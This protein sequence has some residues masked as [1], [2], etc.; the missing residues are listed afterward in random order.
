MK[1]VSQY[2]SGVSILVFYQL[3]ERR[4]LY[5]YLFLSFIAQLT[6]ICCNKTWISSKTVAILIRK[7]FCLLKNTFLIIN[8]II[9]KRLY[10]LLFQKIFYAR[11]LYL[12]AIIR[13]MIIKFCCRMLYILITYSARRK[14]KH[15]IVRA[16]WISTRIKV[17]LKQQ[18][19]PMS[20]KFV[21]NS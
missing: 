10:F 1:S 8:N 16:K 19:F 7:I 6:V 3:D 17:T 21:A 20:I 13:T 11:V 12:V 14:L 18:G 9:D 5:K 2:L 15:K 4:Y